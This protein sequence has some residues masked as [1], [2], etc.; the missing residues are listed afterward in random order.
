MSKQSIKEWLPQERPR[1]RLVEKGP[2]VLSDAELIAIL[3]HSGTKKRS[4][5][6]LAREVLQLVNGKIQNLNQISL[7]QLCGIKGIGKAKAITLLASFEIS[8]RYTFPQEELSDNICNTKMAAKI[9]ISTLRDL[10]HE[11]CWVIFL[12]QANR[13]VAKERVS[14]GGVSGTIVD[15]RI[16]LKSAVNK[17]A[18]GII[19]MHNHPSGNVK[20]GAQDREQTLQ[21]REAAS[22]FGIRL[23]D[24]LIV[25]GNRYYSFAED[26]A[27]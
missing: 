15:T 10:C 2:N 12:N 21:L 20:P 7:Q 9:A 24:H 1:E 22:L 25:A 13:I 19:L 6:D 14:S 26:G 23:L 27:I 11:E 17:L 4:A 16:I 3:I 8:R 18:S 5:V